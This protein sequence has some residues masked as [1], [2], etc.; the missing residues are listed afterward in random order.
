MLG[1]S[2]STI[3]KIQKRLVEEQI[4]VSQV[5][6]YKLLKRYQETGNVGDTPRH[7]IPK[8]LGKEQ[9]VAINEA[10]AANDELTARQLLGILEK[11]WPELEVSVS[12]IK[13]TWRDLGWIATR[14]KYCQLIRDANRSKRVQWCE[15]ILETKEQ[16]KDASF[17]TNVRFNWTTTGAYVF[18]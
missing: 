12:T 15:R 16:F 4:F 8:K 17:Q 13:H 9:L 14:P 5:S 18:V 10:L 11:Q 6:L 1:E 2:G 3:T 7:Q